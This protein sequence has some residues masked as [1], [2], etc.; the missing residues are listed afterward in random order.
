MII[1][2]VCNII[3]VVK[4]IENQI[5]YTE[6][7]SMAE[8]YTSKAFT[9]LLGISK[10]TLF[11]KERNGT[12]PPAKR[13]QRGSISHRYYTIGDIALYRKKLNLKPLVHKLRRQLFLNL[14][15]GSGKSSIAANYAYLASTLGI[16]CLV[17][18]L[19]PEAT[20]TSLL[21]QNPEE[22]AL[23][24]GDILLKNLP[25]EECL[26]HLNPYLD[27][28]PANA[29]LVSAALDLNAINGKE[30][31]LTYALG[32][33]KEHYQLIIIDINSHPDILT[34]NAL[35][36]SDDIIIPIPYGKNSE[37]NLTLIFDVLNKLQGDFPSIHAER[38]MIFLN[39][40][41]LSTNEFVKQ[42]DIIAELYPANLMNSTVR[43][44]PQFSIAGN[45]HKTIFQTAPNSL[46]ALDIR[47]LAE[48]ILNI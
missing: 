5:K 25:L 47:K 42:W 21:G 7:N 22:T 29:Q 40:V 36:A 43:F 15:Q 18:D 24:V 6:T 32:K 8:K 10:T 44:D 3:L 17:L 41:N 14:K 1:F 2:Y 45:N 34:L 9:K 20:L 4:P 13:E 28:A 39:K 11:E 31:R 35:I 33:I 38:I 48:E 16:K 19:D 12:L 37:G 23:N 46:A 26:V 27:L 30:F